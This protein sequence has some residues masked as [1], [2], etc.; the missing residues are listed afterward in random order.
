M[1]HDPL[2]QY[3]D[4]PRAQQAPEGMRV[5]AANKDLP[6]VAMAGNVVYASYGA[7]NLHL[8]ILYPLCAPYA[9]QQCRDYPCIVYVQGSGWHKQDVYRRI[10]CLCELAKCGYVIA[11][12][13]YR[14]STLAPFP[15]Q[16]QDAKTAV[17]W[18][19]AHAAEYSG[20]PARIAIMGDSSGGHTSLMAHL[21]QGEALFD[22][23]LYPEYSDTVCGCAA[24]YPPVDLALMHLGGSPMD[25]ASAASP[26]GLLLGGRPISEVPAGELAVSC[27][28]HWVDAKRSLP[29]TLLL[30]GDNDAT[31]PFGESVKMYEALRHARQDATFYKVENAGHGGPEFW[32]P[33]FIHLYDAFFRRCFAGAK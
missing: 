22:S 15:A 19:R 23:G 31:V 4:F 24:L 29:P 7:T 33:E 21:T 3:R 27:P 13:E 6:A 26:E 28:V 25:H 20:D 16:I 10:P 12:V 9:E 30:H 14:H 1:Q 2:Q 8:Q 32:A 5:H 17:R 18:L 11:L